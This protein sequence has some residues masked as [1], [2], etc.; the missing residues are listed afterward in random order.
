MLKYFL[1]YSDYY[2]KCKSDQ[3]TLKGALPAPGIRSVPAVL[4]AYILVRGK[5]GIPNSACGCCRTSSRLSAVPVTEYFLLPDGAYTS[6]NTCHDG[7]MTYGKKKGIT[8]SIS[9]RMNW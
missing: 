1:F 3:I 2:L 4:F 5:K 8:I 6:R 9:S 7:F